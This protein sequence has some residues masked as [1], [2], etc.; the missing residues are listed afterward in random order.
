MKNILF[1]VKIF[2]AGLKKLFCEVNLSEY[3]IKEFKIL[4]C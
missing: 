1:F 4:F 2:A 3:T